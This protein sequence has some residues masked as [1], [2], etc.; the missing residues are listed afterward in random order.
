MS[1][2][3]SVKVT[4]TPDNAPVVLLVDDEEE[5]LRA[6]TMLLT[7]LN[8]RILTAESAESGLQLLETAIPVVVIS[9]MRMAGMDGADFLGEVARRMPDTTRLLI[10]GQVDTDTTLKAINTGQVH[11]FIPKPWNDAELKKLVADAVKGHMLELRNQKLQGQLKQRNDELAEL[12]ATLEK[13]VSDRTEELRLHARLIEHAFSDLQKSYGHVLRL[14]TSLAVL[15]DPKGSTTAG[16][17]AE[18]AASLAEAA[19]LGEQDIRSVRDAAMLADLGTIGL[20]DELLTKPFTDFDGE[21]L[22]L[23][24]QSPVLAEA[25]LMGVP[26]MQ[27]AAV[28]L[29]H[30]FERFDGS[31]Y[32]DNLTSENIPVGSRI[33]SLVRDY[34]DF[35]RGRFNG[36]E[37]TPAAARAELLNQA[38]RYDARL[39]AV[40]CEQCGAF[41]T[42]PLV[43]DEKRL[44]AAD[45]EPGMVLADDLFSERGMI[46]LTKGHTLTDELIGKL[47]SLQSCTGRELD[48]RVRRDQSELEST[49]A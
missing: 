5:I 16:L 37:M 2:S 24:S 8:A 38:S 41:V 33:I 12:N 49:G 27:Q 14:A 25:A 31:G 1:F 3:S 29:R 9:D 20:P 23:F 11:R 4:T 39:L 10:T 26:G 28:M 19:G 15:R 44:N 35:I 22:R 30:Q 36:V 45:L 13:R 18:M 40:F 48:I 34:T 7:P 6:L 17:R 32:P 21:D 46:L 42:A 47:R 43:A